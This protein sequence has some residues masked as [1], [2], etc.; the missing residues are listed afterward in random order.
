MV[1]LCA[2]FERAT[3]LV[4]KRSSAMPACPVLQTGFTVR[5]AEERTSNNGSWG[6][7]NMLFTVTFRGGF[8]KIFQRGRNFLT[9]AMFQRGAC[10]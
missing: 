3:F 7:T 8:P 2:G 10:I 1:T 6:G 9:T 4:A 5:G